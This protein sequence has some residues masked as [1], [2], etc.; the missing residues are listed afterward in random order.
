MKA[1]PIVVIYKGIICDVFGFNYRNIFFVSVHNHMHI[2]AK[3][4]EDYELLT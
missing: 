3:I 4:L 1:I 2:I